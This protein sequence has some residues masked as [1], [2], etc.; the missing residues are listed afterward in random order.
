MI[1]KKFN[2]FFINFTFV[3]KLIFFFVERNH[4]ELLFSDS[5]FLF[6]RFESSFYRQLDIRLSKFNHRSSTSSHSFAFIFASFSS[7]FEKY[8]S[9]RHID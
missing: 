6:V 2:N 5:A 7:S 1:A 8:I 4:A 9:N 3:V